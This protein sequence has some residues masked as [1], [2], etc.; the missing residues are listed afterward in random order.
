MKNS[1]AIMLSIFLFLIGGYCFSDFSNSPITD[2]SSF[3]NYAWKLE[4]KHW[5]EVIK[6]EDQ[7]IEILY[8]WEVIKEYNQWVYERWYVYNIADSAFSI[9]IDKWDYLIT[10]E[11]I[12]LNGKFYKKTKNSKILLY[13]E[14]HISLPNGVYQLFNIKKGFNNNMWKAENEFE[15]LQLF[16]VEPRSFKIRS[17][18][19][20][21]DANNVYN[22][23]KIVEW[24]DW[25]SFEMISLWNYFKSGWN[26]Y[27]WLP[28]THTNRDGWLE[29]AFQLTQ[30]VDVATFQS[31]GLW[32]TK[33]KN[34]VYQTETIRDV[35][36]YWEKTV[37]LD[38]DTS[39]FELIKSDTT[40]ISEYWKDKEWIYHWSRMISNRIKSFKAYTNN[41]WVDQKNFY[42]DG[43]IIE[44]IDINTI[45]PIYSSDE[46]NEIVF[47]KD[48]N[49]VYGN[50]RGNDC[51]KVW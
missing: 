49:N 11:D 45:E 15:S 36:W 20:T 31:L 32:Y 25:E 23:W 44:W 40:G 8:E 43:Q 16:W 48:E 22:Q 38:A 29:K 35:D 26:I 24:L 13:D 46:K 37:T 28:R 47:F 17:D 18:G 5:Y 4:L 21:S 42:C 41:V 50:G 34:W 12:Y 33:D 27:S 19:I 1:Y 30:D 51:S 6:M 7:K 39:T 14:G 2:Y 10:Y 3:D 9:S